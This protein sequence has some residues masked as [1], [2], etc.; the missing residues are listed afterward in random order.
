MFDMKITP[1]RRSLYQYHPI[2]NRER[3]IWNN[4]IF[5]SEYW[6]FDHGIIILSEQIGTAF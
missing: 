4:N 2:V 3:T 1:K 5:T 6:F